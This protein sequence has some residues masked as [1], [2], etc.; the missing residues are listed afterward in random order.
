[1]LQARTQ[2][3][4]TSVAL[5]IVLVLTGSA[6]MYVGAKLAINIGIVPITG[7]T[8]ALPIVV[9]LL[10][11]RLGTAAVA[12][13]VIEGALGL[14]VFA[15]GASTAAL[16]GP[17]GGYLWA[18]PVA[19]A[20][21]GIA[22]DAGFGADAMR[23]FAAIFLST[24]FVILAGAVWLQIFTGSFQAAFAMGVVPFIIGDLAKCAIASAI[25][26]NV[27]PRIADARK[28]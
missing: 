5:R 16:L 13:Y 17:T 11:T 18:M 12:T 23:R 7:Q 4:A 28:V 8:L 1:M 27:W 6:L 15:H 19:A 22:Y 14:P 20:I 3:P 26:A 21:V 2:S 10:G 25:P 24:A 9:A